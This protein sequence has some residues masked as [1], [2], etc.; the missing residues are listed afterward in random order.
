MKL[1]KDSGENVLRISAYD[2]ASVTVAEQRLTATFALTPQS[3]IAPISVPGISDLTWRRLTDLHDHGIE[4]LVLGT[5]RQQQFPSSAFYA[6]LATARIGLEVM[7]TGAACRTYNIL[8]SEGR[9]VAAV[10]MLNR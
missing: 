2:G 4:I 1:H 9:R 10:I 7:D 6:E 8:A 5:G 3:L